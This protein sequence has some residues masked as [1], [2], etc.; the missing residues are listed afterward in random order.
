MV[1]GRARQR[2][3]REYQRRRIADPALCD[4]RCEV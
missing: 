2:G 1:D 4:M 3:Q